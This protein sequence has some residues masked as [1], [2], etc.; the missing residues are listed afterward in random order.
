MHEGAAETVLVSFACVSCEMRIVP[1]M[2]FADVLMFQTARGTL[3][4]Q[5]QKQR[6]LFW[7]RQGASVMMVG[8]AVEL[9]NGFG[10]TDG[11][12]SFIGK[13]RRE[14]E[15]KHLRERQAQ[16]G[17]K[18]VKLEREVVQQSGR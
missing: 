7:P 8:G 9:D 13:E 18:G 17:G 5:T 3:M 16:E 6:R 15:G 11:R 12:S 2:S 10:W 1:Y 14:D 4:P